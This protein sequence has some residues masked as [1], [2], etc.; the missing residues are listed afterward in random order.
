MKLLSQD[1]SVRTYD[2]GERASCLDCGTSIPI[3]ITIFD[4]L[5]EEKSRTN[6]PDICPKCQ[7]RRDEDSLKRQRMDQVRRLFDVAALGPRFAQ[8]TFE[9]WNNRR[10]LAI[11]YKICNDYAKAFRD[12]KLTGQGIVLM[13]ER[14][15][16][17]THLAAA[18]ANQL[19][20]QLT[21]VIFQPVPKLIK[22]IQST[23]RR[24]SEEQE[25]D[26]I[27]ALTT[28]DLLI[29]DDVG[30]EKWSENREET[31]YNIVDERYRQLLPIIFTTNCSMDELEEQIG[32][33]SY[34][35]LLEVCRFV[36]ME[37][38]SW[39]VLKAKGEV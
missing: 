36:R 35:R 39:R 2:T 4:F 30:A 19:L 21:T 11:A 17:K 25:R 15:T 23:Y 33:R 14:G 26:I 16:G 8:C 13:G 3:T 10:E 34:D 27:A 1:D 5:G 7:K 22:R 38:E 29:L 37:A 31:L 32:S 28:C 9:N 6:H 12:A 24:G 20:E 18:I